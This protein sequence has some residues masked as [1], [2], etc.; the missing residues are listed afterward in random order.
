MAAPSNADTPQYT[1]FPLQENPYQNYY[2]DTSSR[3]IANGMDPSV[4]RT[5]WGNDDFSSAAFDAEQTFLR[6]RSGVRKD[7]RSQFQGQLPYA[8][9][10][11]Q[12]IMP[13]KQM[14]PETT[15]ISRACFNEALDESG[16]F[17]LRHWQIWDYAPFLP[18]NGDVTQDP[19][20]GMQTKGFTTDYIPLSGKR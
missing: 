8:T 18:S 1:A 13:Q 6:T 12:W 10:P 11:K 5:Q 4:F 17:Y 9:T 19:R 2:Q 3:P 16:P 7:R 20:Y 15:R 14:I